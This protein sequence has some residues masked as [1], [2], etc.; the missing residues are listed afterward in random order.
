MLNVGQHGHLLS[1]HA[2]CFVVFLHFALFGVKS[3]QEE[4][5]LAFWLCCLT[6][7]VS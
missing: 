4:L 1:L 5:V 2:C 6:D 7:L 3:S